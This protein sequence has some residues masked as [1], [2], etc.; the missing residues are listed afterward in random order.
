M[1]ITHNKCYATFEDFSAAML[2]FLWGGR[3]KE[4][5]YLLR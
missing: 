4:L 2:K 3:T 1:N 5:A